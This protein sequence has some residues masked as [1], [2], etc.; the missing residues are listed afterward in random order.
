M[1]TEPKQ[2]YKA[3]IDHVYVPGGQYGVWHLSDLNDCPLNWMG[4]SSAY[5]SG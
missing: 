2:S 4:E 1:V 5:L 3:Y